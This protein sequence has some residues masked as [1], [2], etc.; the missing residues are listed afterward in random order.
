[1]SAESKL[2]VGSRKERGPFVLSAPNSR[3][4]RPSAAPTQHWS[5]PRTTP[6]PHRNLPVVPLSWG[7]RYYGETMGRGRRGY[8]VR[9]GDRGAAPSIIPKKARV[10]PICAMEDIGTKADWE[11]PEDG[12][13]LQWPGTARSSGSLGRCFCTSAAS[14]GGLRPNPR[15]K[16]SGL[17]RGSAARREHCECR[18]AHRPA[19]ELSSRPQAAHWRAPKA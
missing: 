3:A 9:A 12:L 18:A 17:A 4:L 19:R 14:S 11:A 13:A 7:Q 2:Q 10:V 16:A 8:G 6:D 5:V 15:V 1:M